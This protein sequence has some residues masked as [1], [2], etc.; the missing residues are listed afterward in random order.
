MFQ[1][2]ICGPT[3]VE[4]AIAAADAGADAVGLNFVPG[5]R[6]C[7]DLARAERIAEAVAGRLQLVGVFVNAPPQQVRHLHDRLKLDAVQLHGDEA[8]EVLAELSDL[9]LVRA[10]R[11]GLSDDA[12][13]ALAYLE[14]C[15]RQACLPQAVLVDAF[16]P[17]AYG[18]TGQEADWPSARR[19][20][21]QAGLPLI[22]AG[23]LT[24]ANVES[25][26]RQVQPFGVDT[27]S[28]V[29]SHAGIKDPQMCRDF[30]AAARRA[31]AAAR[32][33]SR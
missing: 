5:T 20:V 27:A 16:R 10:F 18:G 22:L 11:V 12:E 21:Q 3:T 9:P 32:A 15:R 13:A 31:L 8:V 2:K 6:R 1:I 4:S 26:V 33:E 23:G 14:A 29:E 28:G 30:V 25:A 17:G 7:L 19:L 24:A